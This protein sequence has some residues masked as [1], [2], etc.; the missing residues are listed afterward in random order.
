MLSIH[1]QQIARH[2]GMEKLGLQVIIA[3]FLQIKH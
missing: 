1:T 3:H 2:Q